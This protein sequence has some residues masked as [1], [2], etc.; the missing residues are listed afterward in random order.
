MPAL[1]T[2]TMAELVTAYND[3]A[4][5]PVKTFRNKAQGIAALQLLGYTGEPDAEPAA[6]SSD[7]LEAMGQDDAPIGGPENDHGDSPL[8]EDTPPATSE[9]SSLV[10]QLT[11]ETPPEPAA[12]PS[13]GLTSLQDLCN[14]LEVVPR[15]ARRRLR[16]AFG[17][18]EEG[19]WEFAAADLDA[20]RKIIAGK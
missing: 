20:V 19:R 12:A 13:S 18:L 8:E 17:T 14:E 15:I 7:W 9:L 5:S 1:N 10:G 11:G 16:K 6:P 3:L 2:L 4:D